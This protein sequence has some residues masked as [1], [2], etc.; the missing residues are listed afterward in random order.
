MA[1]RDTYL[2][3]LQQ[4]MRDQKQE[5][6]NPADLLAY[7][8]TARKEVALYAQCIRVL[9]PISS[10]ILSVNVTSGGSGYVNPTVVIT[11]PDFPSGYG[12][13][14]GGRQATALATLNGNVISGIDI[15][16]GGSGY[17]QPVVTVTDAVGTGA[18]ATLSLGPM[19]LLKQGQ[20]VYNF[21]D[22]D[23]SQ[24]SGVSAVYYVR[25][26]SII[27]A[28]YRYSIPIYA[29]SEYQA[30]IRQ[31]PFQYQYVPTFGT[32][33]GQGTSGS[34]YVYPLPSQ[35]YQMEW[36]CLCLP[37]DLADN[38][39]VEVL[40][41]PWTGAVK[42]YASHLVMLERGNFNAAKMYYDRFEQSV[43]HYSNHTRI[44]RIV[45]P[46]GRY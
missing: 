7:V 39:S 17:F 3:Q 15:V 36:D 19:N 20:E 33:F 34:L 32:F 41:D 28:D 29:F 42:W 30:K 9:T 6:Q 21:S 38:L 14:P 23:L 4:L 13:S 18:A 24:N 27:Y 44:G 31:Y 5:W 2:Q 12:S 11:P 45:N 16:D 22:I 26:V 1:T 43:L 37:A 40:P 46:Y 25:S 8:N 35:T 10:Q